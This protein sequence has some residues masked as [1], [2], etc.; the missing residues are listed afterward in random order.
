M[1]NC[2]KCNIEVYKDYGS[3][4]FCSRKCSNSKIH[5]EETKEK[6]SSK[7]KGSISPFKG[8]NG[9]KH[10]L[11]F[12]I[13]HSLKLKEVYKNNPELG[14]KISV[15][16]KGKPLSDKTKL[17]ISYKLKGKTGGIRKGSSRG[18]SGWY[19]GYWCDSSWELAYIIFNLEHNIKFK[20]NIKG[21]EYINSK[22][23][24]KRY[25]PDFILE[26]GEY[27]EIKNFTTEDVLL[28][29]QALINLDLKIT[30]IDKENINPYL[31]Y[32]KNKYG[33]NFIEL[34]DKQN[35]DA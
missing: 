19:K 24:N 9:K 1:Y 5:S 21:F 16:L 15:R 20:R 33:K 25:F 11:E 3:K 27:I 34:Y 2:E 12:K 30:I 17:K 18:K 13:K 29:A 31:E 32:V 14:K 8:K 28:K 4:R 35:L 23:E 7:L 10:T 6:I 26:S 22:K